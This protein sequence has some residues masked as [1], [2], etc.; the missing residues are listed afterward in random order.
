MDRDPA[1][2][3]RRPETRARTVAV[4][5]AVTLVAALAL[6]SLAMPVAAHAYLSETDPGNGEQVET[7]P[8]DVT[9][10]FSGDGVQNADISVVDPDGE[11]VSD[12]PEIDP[13]DTQLVDVPLEV[14]GDDAPEGMYTVEWEVLADDGHTTSG[15]F[16]FSLGDEPLDRDTVL[17]AYEDDDEVDDEVPPLETAAK[18]LLLVALVGLVGGP[19]AAALA[20]YP[21][22][23][24]FNASTRVL[25]R[26]LKRLLAGTAAVL[27]ASVL[28]L[29]YVQASAVGPLSLETILEFLGMPLGQAWLV[30]F[31]AAL[32]VCGALA[33]GFAGIGSRPI[34]L[35]GTALGS[36][37]VGG[38]V[39]WT[40]HSAT[41]ID[42]VQGMAVD[43][44]HIGGAALWVG[45]LVVLALVVPAVLRETAPA[46]RSALAAGTIRRYSLLA[47]T[48]V[49][50]AGATGLALAAWHVPSLSALSDSIYGT[51]LSAKTLLVLLALGLGGLTR[52]ILLRHLESSPADRGGLTGRL[53]ETGDQLRE[54]GGE[55]PT[56]RATTSFVRAVRLEVAVLVVVLL[57]SGLLTSV[58][59]AAVV[60]GEEDD[61]EPATIEL[62]GDDVDMLLT[63]LPGEASAGASG[64]QFHL[65]ENE[66][67]V[68]EVA[69]IESGA[70]ADT[71]GDESDA[72]DIDSDELLESDQ[73]VRLTA[74]AVDGDTT[75]DIE[76]EQ[77]DDGTYAAVQPFADDGNWDIRVTGSPDGQ[78]VSEWV[79]A[80]VAAEGDH[81]HDDH[82]GADDHDHEHDHDDQ[83]AAD[84]SEHD[85]D[86][87]TDS[88]FATLLQFGAITIGIIGSLAV[89]VESVRLRDRG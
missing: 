30:Q 70:D 31:V 60:G 33:L 19:A 75:F 28:T 80:Y 66:P 34:W 7:L 61:L 53:F 89:V 71:E 58:P 24:R 65:E 50:L 59:T 16:F 23:D 47:L 35:G 57:L 10:T 27:L 18:G 39:S 55:P 85:H 38:A 3:D 5:A 6:S 87:D 79:E 67:I 74:D 11:E 84:D 73:T 9:L 43:F 83:A 29:G 13:D 4:L 36:I 17:E 25:D 56:D 82:N 48:G 42:R 37:I 49:T 77:T 64:E 52:F 32:A 26:R 21:V 68:F 78:F 20:V 1:S 81:D 62:E 40:S 63:A 51:A 14:N 2:P 88:A 72:A 54:D 12:D 45:G 22:T 44:V 69:F 41:A 86:P 15:S 8:E 46:D 76:L